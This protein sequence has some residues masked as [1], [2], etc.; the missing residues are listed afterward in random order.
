MVIIAAI[1]AFAALA[2]G[3]PTDRA[4]WLMT[5]AWRRVASLTLFVAAALIGLPGAYDHLQH[6]TDHDLLVGIAIMV[7]L[8]LAKQ[9][10]RGRSR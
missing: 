9:H 7:F 3:D 5:S 4:E 2:C 1:L 6:A 10:L 8:I